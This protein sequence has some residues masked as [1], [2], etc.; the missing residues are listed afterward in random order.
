MYHRIKSV[1]KQPPTPIFNIS[2]S[3]DQT[4]GLCSRSEVYYLSGVHNH[5]PVSVDTRAHRAVRSCGWVV[6][7]HKRPSVYHALDDEGLP[8]LYHRFRRYRS[9]A[10]LRSPHHT[11]PHQKAGKVSVLIDKLTDQCLRFDDLLGCKNRYRKFDNE[12]TLL[13]VVSKEGMRESDSY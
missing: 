2:V 11:T 3:K 7:D 1:M 5:P 12:V 4:P 6:A 10:F 8:P 13:C 9:R